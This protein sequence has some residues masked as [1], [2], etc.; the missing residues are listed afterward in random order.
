MISINGREYPYG[1][2]QSLVEFFS[3][4]KMEIGNGIALA[5]NEVVIPKSQWNTYMLH[6]NDKIILIKATQGG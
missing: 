5:V 2:S 1:I 4:L 3:V 6:D